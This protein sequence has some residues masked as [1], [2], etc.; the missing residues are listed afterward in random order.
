[1]SASCQLFGSDLR[2]RET[3]RDAR[4]LLPILLAAPKFDSTSALPECNR[5]GRNFRP[6]VQ[7]RPRHAKVEAALHR[8]CDNGDVILLAE[9]LGRESD[10]F[11]DLPE[12]AAAQSKPKNSPEVGSSLRE[13]PTAY[14]KSA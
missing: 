4:F 13:S 14:T 6:F 5:C 9:E 7:S 1:M 12:I 10:K 11:N 2:D 3:W 8:R